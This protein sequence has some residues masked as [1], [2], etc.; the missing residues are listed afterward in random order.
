VA[1]IET[2][3]PLEAILAAAGEADLVVMGSRG[4]GALSGTPLGSLS[5][6][7]VTSTRTPVLVIH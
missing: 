5:Q 3:P 1:T 7:V 2:K 4:R 6:R